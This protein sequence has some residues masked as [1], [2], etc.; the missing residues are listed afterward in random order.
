MMADFT[1]ILQNLLS[2]NNQE[3]DEA[4]RR[5]NTLSTAD[6]MTHL[7]HIVRN[8]QVLEIRTIGAV[9]VRR[10]CVQ[11]GPEVILK[12]PE[13]I[14][15]PCQS[16]LLMAVQ[17][18]PNATLR[19]KISEAIAEMARAC[20]DDDETN[21]W[22]VGLKFLFDCCN[23]QA[24]HL[25]EVALN[26]IMSVPGIF[27]N[28][29]NH[30]LGVIK[31]MLHQ[32]LDHPHKEVWTAAF[33]ATVAFLKYQETD[34]QRAQFGDL[35]PLMIR[36]LQQCVQEASDDSILQALVDLC[37]ECPTYIRPHFDTVICLCVKMAESEGVDES[38]RH[39][40]IEVIVSVAENAPGM[41]RKYGKKYIP[42]III[43]G[44]NLM[45]DIV[46]DE[47]WSQVDELES[48]D[49]SSNESVG[50][51]T[52]DR[53][54]ISLGGRAILQHIMTTL[55]AMFKSG[56]WKH[57]H[58]ALMAVSVVAEGCYKEMVKVLDQVVEFIIPF[59]QDSVSSDVYVRISLARML[60]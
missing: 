20:I 34:K 8:S 5:Y 19:R 21:H 27:G 41:F 7:V 51:D 53:L 43:L 57:R 14:L 22:Q 48:A 6:K 31:Q 45:L 11:S 9:L 16:E 39:L 17:S 1:V 15:K 26:I 2:T 47:E 33:K 44:L 25:Y 37:T 36:I 49:E 30:Y 28:Q 12:L 10:L 29:Q 4:E 18:E 42:S 3:R 32:A 58:T 55:P 24:P 59:C 54:A 40:S 13:D 56:D 60:F 50:Q 52:L 35:L 23:P 46:D 38:W